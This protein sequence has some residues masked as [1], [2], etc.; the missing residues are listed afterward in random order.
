M[1][2]W[3][4][5]A[6]LL[7]LA[8]FATGAAAD[9]R[10]LDYHSDIQILPDTSIEVH[11]TI[12]VRSEGRSIRHGIFRDFPTTYTDRVGNPYRVGFELVDVRR[13]GQPE[14]YTQDGL[15]NGVRIKIGS[16]STVLPPG[17]YIY[18]ITYRAQ[19]ELGFFDGFDE[20]YWNVTGIGWIFPI[21]KAS[22]TVTLPR[23]VAADQL[24][25]AGY[26][27]YQASHDHNVTMTRLNDTQVSFATSVPLKSSQG[28]TIAIGLPKGV[29][30]NPRQLSAERTFSRKTHPSSSRPSGWS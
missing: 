17:E 8:L 30:N 14:P 29:V 24:R 15:S 1:R 6:V 11:E 7:V 23:P 28:L 19:R 22:A 2:H 21:D 16:A 3:C 20:L 4:L 13:D 26:T 5:L 18:E 27:G 9:E 12:R 25:L 10:I